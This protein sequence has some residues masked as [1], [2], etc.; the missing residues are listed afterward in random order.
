MHRL[1]ITPLVKSDG[2]ESALVQIQVCLPVYDRLLPPI[3][4]P[5]ETVL[6]T[7]LRGCL[8][9]TYFTQ[10]RRC[11]KNLILKILGVFLR[12]NPSSALNLNKLSHFQTASKAR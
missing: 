11:Q 5:L 4:Y 1:C 2:Y 10:F 7:S 6:K 3:Y 8:K 12:L 9:I